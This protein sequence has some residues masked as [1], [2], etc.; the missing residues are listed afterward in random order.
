MMLEKVSGKKS[1]RYAAPRRTGRCL[2]CGT[3]D[4]KRGR[5]Y[6]SEECRDQM[7]WVLSLS[8]G[9]LRAFNARY[10]AFF[11]SADY[12]VLDVLPVWKT[13][14]SRFIAH[15]RP[16]RKPAADLKN[17]ILESG[18]EWYGHLDRKNS[19]SVASLRLLQDNHNPHVDP[20]SIK[21][22]HR[23]RPR[24][25]KD[26]NDCLKLLK[27]EREV[28]SSEGCESTIKKAY[29][30]LA[31]RYHPD[32]GGDEEIFKRLNEAH[33]QMLLWVENPQYTCR[34]ALQ[35][36][37]SYDGATSRWTPPL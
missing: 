3:T 24:L 12:V 35:D 29:K 23:S 15:R 7:R 36:S 30:R 27:I 28:L 20:R 31:K 32:M 6:C 17:L 14:I 21:P 5:R 19:K 18:E 11:F 34:K 9:L 26:E 2:S 10:A 13:G 16:G 8:K 33:Q 1:V 4:M 22:S 25:S 37:W